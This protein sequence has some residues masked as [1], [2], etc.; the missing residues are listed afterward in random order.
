MIDMLIGPDI[1]DE[2]KTGHSYLE[3]LQ[4]VLPELLEGVPLVTRIAM[5]F[6]HDG[7]SS[8]ATRL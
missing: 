3:F 6:Q 4:N 7:F 2:S 1:L 8:H 5:Y